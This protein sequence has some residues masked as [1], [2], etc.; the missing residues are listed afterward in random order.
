MAFFHSVLVDSY[1]V[2]ILSKASFCNLADRVKNIFTSFCDNLSSF[3][4]IHL[5]ARV[6]E[7]DS[8]EVPVFIA[9]CSVST[10][11]SVV[12]NKSFQ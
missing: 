6:H 11:N 4:L 2:S 7:F 3:S 9:I 1:T 12:S 10:K 8:L 5:S